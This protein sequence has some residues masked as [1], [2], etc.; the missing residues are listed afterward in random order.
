MQLPQL[1]GPTSLVHTRACAAQRC[2]VDSLWLFHRYV[3][4]LGQQQKEG[5]EQTL[6]SRTE[7]NC[8]DLTWKIL[9]C[10]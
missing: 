3:D 6:Q 9:I 4:A 10:G 8:V 7:S 2:T 1:H 5:E